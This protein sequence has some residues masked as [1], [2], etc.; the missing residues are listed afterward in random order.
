MSHVFYD[1]A[2]ASSAAKGSDGERPAWD[3]N[4]SGLCRSLGDITNLLYEPWIK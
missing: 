4:A 2:V 3:F 1:R